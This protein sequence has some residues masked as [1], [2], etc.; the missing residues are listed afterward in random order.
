MRLHIAIPTR[1]TWEASFGYSLANL[2][3]A[4]AGNPPDDLASV[5]LSKCESTI[6]PAGRT[7]LV[8]DA[9]GH[10][11]THILFLDD[12]MRF[13]VASVLALL[14]RS[15]LD[16]VACTYPKRRPPHVMTAQ[17]L[18]GSR[19]AP[20]HGLVEAAHVGFGLALIRAEVFTRL[21]KPWFLTPWSETDDD[22]MGEDVWFC[23]RAR[24]HGLKV[25]VDR[26]ASRRIAHIGT[27]AFEAEPLQ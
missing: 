18:D 7:D 2:L 22:F 6:I 12:D 5:R 4:L 17:A 26:D 19:I 23:A 27:Q 3:A 21:P 25:W 15:E 8:K 24:E 16:I 1:G 10:D 14:G 9:L 20:G 11:A 13:P